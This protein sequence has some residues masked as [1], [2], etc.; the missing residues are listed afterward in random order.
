MKKQ[1]QPSDQMIG[2]R[3]GWLIVDLPSLRR[4]SSGDVYWMCIC[5]C[6]NT[7]EAIGHNLRSGNT[8]SC[9][10]LRTLL[11]AARRLYAEYIASRETWDT[12]SEYYTWLRGHT[13]TDHGKLIVALMFARLKAGQPLG[14]MH[15]PLPPSRS[16]NG[17]KPAPIRGRNTRRGRNPVIADM[18]YDGWNTRESH[19]EWDE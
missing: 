10:C 5:R 7:T 17:S 13:D 6:G 3:F 18:E 19:G 8:L 14:K 15:F 1:N 16:V 12:E 4:T 9:G 11:P 2:Q